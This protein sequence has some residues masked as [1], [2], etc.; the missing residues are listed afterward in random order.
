MNKK[1]AIWTLLLFAMLWIPAGAAD[2]NG[3]SQAVVKSG[4][5]VRDGYEDTFF[6]ADEKYYHQFPDGMEIGGFVGI[7]DYLEAGDPIDHYQSMITELISDREDSNAVAMWSDAASV[8]DGGRVWGGFISARSGL[9]TGQDSQLIGLEVD[10]LNGG[11][12]GEAPNASKVGV[13]IVGFGELTTNAVEILTDERGRWQSG[14][15]IDNGAMAEDG[16]VFGCTQNTPVALGIDF[17]STPFSEAAMAVSNNSKIIMQ[18][19]IGE[20][21]AVYTDDIGDGSLVFRAGVS[22]L[23][24][25]SNDGRKDLLTLKAD[26]SLDPKCLVYQSMQNGKIGG[27][28]VI[29]GIIGGLVLLCAF[30]CMRLHGQNMRLSEVEG[31]VAALTETQAR[32]SDE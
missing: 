4:Y 6:S 19:I 25:T 7:S 30:L 9:E 13:Q 27:S 23:R 26:G 1:K 11:L 2:E 15:V 24:I 3:D 29:P 14:I 20:P 28:P 8:A 21:A 31:L 16:T 32:L 22:G 5:L 12:P 10:V 18:S 17:R